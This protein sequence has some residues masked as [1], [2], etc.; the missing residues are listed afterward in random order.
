MN[1]GKNNTSKGD[2]PTV[3]IAEHS[4]CPPGCNIMKAV[5]VPRYGPSDVLEMREVE[6][7]SPG[8]DEV[9]VR[10][11]AS[12]VN[13]TD[14]SY[15]RGIPF[16]SRL[17]TGLL[18]PRRS[19]PG[20]EFSGVVE[21]VGD[22]V[23]SLKVGD[24]V[25]GLSEKGYGTHSEFFTISENSPIAH[26]PEG[27]SFKEAAASSEGPWY[28]INFINKVKIEPGQ[29]ILVN[30][31]TGGIGSAT[32]QLLRDRGA[33]VTAVCPG[34]YSQQVRTLGANEVIDYE[35][36]DFTRGDITYD[37]VFDTVG[38]SSFG[39]SKR[40]L[41]PGGIYI[42]S[43][44]GKWGQNVFYSLVT[45]IFFSKKVRFPFPADCRGS[46]LHMKK[47]LEEGKYRPLIDRKFG[48]EEIVDAYRYVDSGEKIGNVVITVVEP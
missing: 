3:V 35:E 39:S 20:T 10:I 33:H 15:I 23:S 2:A 17:F 42:S 12:T 48:M 26:I 34:R 6:K 29:R 40:I 22:R 44:L 31:G 4:G 30:G 38:K 32:I 27:V 45:P 7:P 14:T 1:G 9:L 36:E 46:I 13:R 43:E 16:F 8:D 28:A 25:F 19:I 18:K 37:F 47:L 5:V 24:R 41:K 11:H 21:A